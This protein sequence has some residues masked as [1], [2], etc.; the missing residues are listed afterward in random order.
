MS[1]IHRWWSVQE[2]LSQ[3]LQKGC[4]VWILWQQF[5]FFSWWFSPSVNIH[6]NC[7]LLLTPFIPLCPS[8]LQIQEL[9]SMHFPQLCLWGEL[10]WRGKRSPGTSKSEYLLQNYISFIWENI[11]MVATKNLKTKLQ[12]IFELKRQYKDAPIF[13]TCF[14]TRQTELYSACSPVT[15]R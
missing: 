13:G 12:F 4:V 15:C 5:F 1:L 9:H 8:L 7:N 10:R 3:R 6:L 14:D 2:G 11:Q